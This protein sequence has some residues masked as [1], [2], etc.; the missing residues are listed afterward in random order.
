MRALICAGCGRYFT[1][2]Q[3][4]CRHCRRACRQRAFERRR[5]GPMAP[6]TER[7]LSCDEPL[8]QAR[9]RLRQYCGGRCRTRAW[10]RRH[11]MAA[12]V[13]RLHITKFADGAELLR[14]H[15]P[16]EWDWARSCVWDDCGAPCTS[17]YGWWEAGAPSMIGWRPACSR[18]HALAVWRNELD[19]G[20]E[21]ASEQ[22]A[23]TPSGG[24]G[25]S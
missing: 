18:K 10:R 16:A 2:F 9:T 20:P 1:S 13:T 4:G 5:R 23:A 15:R 12:G 8:Y 11:Q 19:T 22:A 14:M 7:C 21:L 3:P 25:Q 24:P 6:R 17:V